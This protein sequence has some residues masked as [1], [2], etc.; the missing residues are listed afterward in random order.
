MLIPKFGK[1]IMYTPNYNPIALLNCNHKIISKVINNRTYGLLPKL[2]NYDQSGFIRG[3]NIVDNIRLILD[4]IDYAN[5]KNV[6]GA[7]LFLDLCE[8]FDFL[9]WS[10]IIKMLKSYGFGNKIINWIKIL[11]KKPKC[12]VINNYY[13]SLFFLTLKKG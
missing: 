10:F 11:Y 3:Q 6:P 7:V 12:R 5:C 13:L 2:I 4:I 8:A 1:N 9:K